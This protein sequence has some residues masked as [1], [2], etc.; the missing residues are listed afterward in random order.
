[1]IGRSKHR[2]VAEYHFHR[3]LDFSMLGRKLFHH[4]RDLTPHWSLAL[5]RY[6]PAVDK[7]L[8][9]IRNNIPLQPALRSINVQSRFHLLNT[10]PR[11]RVDPR[12]SFTDLFSQ[13]LQFLNQRRTIFDGVDACPCTVIRYSASPRLAMCSASIPLSAERQ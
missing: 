4:T 6:E 12:S 10:V 7:N 8:E 5:F 3:D 1:M 11:L 13:L 2:I 9:S